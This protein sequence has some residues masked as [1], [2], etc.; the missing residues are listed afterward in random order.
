MALAITGIAGSATAEGSMTIDGTIFKGK[1]T[2]AP[3]MWDNFSGFPAGTL[4]ES[5]SG[6]WQVYS[7]NEASSLPMYSSGD[8]RYADHTYAKIVL[9]G[10]HNDLIYKEDLNFRS[11]FIYLNFWAK[12]QHISKQ[13]DAHA[14]NQTKFFNINA[15]SVGGTMTAP[16]LNYV[17][18]TGSDDQVYPS[19]GWARYQEYWSQG[20]TGSS[21]RIVSKSFKNEEWDNYQIEIYTGTLDGDDGWMKIRHGLDL[22]TI[23][24]WSFYKAVSGDDS[25]SAICFGRYYHDDVGDGAENDIETQRYGDIYVDNTFSRVEVGDEATYDDCSHREIQIVH[26]WSNSEIQI[27]S[28]FGAFTN[29]VGKYM[30]VINSAGTASNGYLIQAK[31]ISGSP[32]HIQQ[33][34]VEPL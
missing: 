1:E 26:S 32:I 21:L 27:N 23:S 15:S 8:G 33:D 29:F 28:R 25:F 17:C 19:H 7:L 20:T 3:L 11:R 13:P 30:Y 24:G 18:S 12:L 34:N 14:N 9:A 10:S 4:V 2:A 5:G 16:S 6:A 31:T 22:H